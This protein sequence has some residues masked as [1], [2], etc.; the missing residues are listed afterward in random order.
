M[1]FR[2]DQLA[3]Q[4]ASKILDGFGMTTTGQAVRPD[5]Q[6]IDVWHLP[7][8]GKKGR[9]C[10]GLFGRMTEGPCILEPYQK[11]PGEDE[12]RECIRKHL[13]FHHERVIDAPPGG[14]KS[15]VA[16]ATCW[17]VSAGRP[18]ASLPAFGFTPATG[19]P[20]GVY[21]TVPGL[22]LK[23]AVVTELPRSRETLFVRLMGRGAVFQH[24]LDDLVALPPGSWERIVALPVLLGLRYD[25]PP[26]PHVRTEEEEILVVTSQ[27][28]VEA[29]WREG[30][31]KGVEKGA[32]NALAHLFERRLKRALREDERERLRERTEA[33]GPDRL[34]DI[35]LDLSVE[36]LAAWLADPDAR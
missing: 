8:E 32:T 9:A 34:G 3:K 12:L 33:L 29:L 10:L 15:V 19:W 26:D 5:A 36:E 17:I 16:F 25:L 21:D 28:M 18:A 13:S 35:V 2:H 22:Q 27:Q 11:P 30:M 1:Y 24:A 20:R 7:G 31:E 14:D 4:L 6:Q 23:L